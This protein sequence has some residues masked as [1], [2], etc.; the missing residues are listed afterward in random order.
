MM[1]PRLPDAP[2]NPETI[3]FLPGW[4]CGTTAKFAPL[5]AS[6]N[7]AATAVAPIRAYVG[8]LAIAP[9]QIKTI[10]WTTEPSQSDQ[11]ASRTMQ[12]IIQNFFPSTPTTGYRESAIYPPSGR[13]TIFNNPYIAAQ[14]PA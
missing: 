5:L 10:P 8:I 13:A 11:I 1:P 9:M 3:P 12:N 7:I 6:V 14:S 2:V 4:T